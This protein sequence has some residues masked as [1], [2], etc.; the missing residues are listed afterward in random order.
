MIEPN[1]VLILGAG[2]SHDYGYPL[3]DEL[4]DKVLAVMDEEVF[5]AKVIDEFNT[6]FTH[7]VHEIINNISKELSHPKPSSIDKYIIRQKDNVKLIIR[8]ALSK[9]ILD[10]EESQSKPVNDWYLELYNTMSEGTNCSTFG[11][12]NNLSVISFNYDR[13]FEHFLYQKLIGDYGQEKHL[14]LILY[15]MDIL[16]PPAYT[17]QSAIHLHTSTFLL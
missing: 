6:S 4:I 5:R 16:P 1:T 13:S 17:Q 10:C 9:I 15:Q 8:M 14:L 12:K 3:G 2:A 7:S 11:I